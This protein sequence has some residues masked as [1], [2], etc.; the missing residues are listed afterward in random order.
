MAK[1]QRGAPAPA[2]P[3]AA[4][5]E[6]TTI[7]VAGLPPDATPRELDNL[8]RF[9]P[10]FVTSKVDTKKAL[11]VFARFDQPG[12]AQLA[13]STLNGHPFD[14][15]SPQE[16]M[17]VVMAKNNMRK[18]GPP[19]YAAQPPS[20]FA[21]GGPPAVVA[22]PAAWGSAP[23][24]KG[25]AR[26]VENPG[27]VDTVASVGAAEAGYDD[28]RLAEFF[29]QLPGFVAFKPNPR[30]GGG[31][32]KFQSAGFAAEAVG[33]AELH[34]VPAAVAKSSMGGFGGPQQ[35]LPPAQAHPGFGG[36]GHG[37]KGAAKGPPA[38]AVDTV[39]CV[40][41][42]NAG[43]D[44]TMLQGFF[45]TCPGFVMFKPNQR[46]GG[47]FAKFQSPHMAAQALDTARKQGIPADMAKSSMGVPG[48]APADPYAQQGG[49][50]GAKRPRMTENP[51]QVD[52][53]ACVGASEAGFDADKLQEFFQL[54]PGF[55]AF[56]A[57]PRMGGGFAKFESA[58]FA[59][60]AVAIAAET[61]VPAAIA[62]S[63][64]GTTADM[65]L[66]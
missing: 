23:M 26:R 53:V 35:P 13:V 3:T 22:P 45:E 58:E 40:G 17:R 19:G 10:G 51:S 11:T 64:M 14:R 46:M 61:G 20:A 28:F 1:G 50:R 32:A 52:T 47:G 34:G 42:E 36:W 31:F 24:G 43:Y 57:N 56:K 25:G 12:N 55:L 15:N 21:R 63:S 5:E 49:P 8:C 7:F 48:M 37:G 9:M 33:V 18:D 60:E 44:A 54:L 2:L 16:L 27:Q 41:A 6:V 65:L 4:M 30:M 66:S 62:K 38:A 29:S 59:S 39:A